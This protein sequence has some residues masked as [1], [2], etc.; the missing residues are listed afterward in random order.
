MT[1]PPVEAIP[2]G[3]EC[4]F[5]AT[6]RC[7][8]ASKCK[9]RHVEHS[10]KGEVKKEWPTQW[11]KHAVAAMD[12]KDMRRTWVARTSLGILMPMFMETHGVPGRILQSRREGQRTRFELDT[13]VPNWL[14]NSIVLSLAKKKPL[15]SQEV[16]LS[17]DSDGTERPDPWNH[18]SIKLTNQGGIPDTLYHCTSLWAALGV[19]VTGHLVASNNCRPRAVYFAPSLDDN[20]NYDEGAIFTAKIYGVHPGTKKSSMFYHSVVPMGIVLHNERSAKD[21][22]CDAFSHQLLSVTIDTDMLTKFLQEWFDVGKPVLPLPLPPMVTMPSHRLLGGLEPM[23]EHVLQQLTARHDVLVERRAQYVQAKTCSVSG[24]EDTSSAST[25]VGPAPARV[26]SANAIIEGESSASASLG[27]APARN[28]SPSG[29]GGA[30]S[31]SA[32]VARAITFLPQSSAAST[33]E[34]LGKRRAPLNETQLGTFYSAVALGMMRKL[35]AFDDGLWEDPK[36]Q[37]VLEA[38]SEPICTNDEWA[39]MPSKKQRKRKNDPPVDYGKWNCHTCGAKYDGGPGWERSN[40]RK[41]Y[42]PKCTLADV[43]RRRPT[44]SPTRIRGSGCGKGQG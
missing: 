44:K 16:Y 22:M 18:E 35:G 30:S 42:C 15:S 9:F 7:K 20:K 40:S 34:V 2:A 17:H 26:L 36:R 39:A 12:S 41:W 10:K 43:G 23:A 25:S 4:S 13:S 6:G 33:E 31:A 11:Q 8:R 1:S 24:I 37:L 14:P 21:W 28:L 27:S 19:T 38:Q 5:F 32:S 29:S 3:K